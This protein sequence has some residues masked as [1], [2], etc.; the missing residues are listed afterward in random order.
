MDLFSNACPDCGSDAVKVHSRYQTAMNG[1]RRIHHCQNCDAYFSDTVATPI[2][3]LQTALSRVILILTARSEG[4]GMNAAARTFHV[5]KKSIIDWEWRLSDVKPTLL[6]Y[7]LVH[8][9]LDQIIEGDELYTKV[10]KNTAACDSEGWTI[11]LMERGSRFLWELDCGPKDQKLFESALQILAE[12]IEQTQDVTLLSDGERRYGNILF[13]IC[14][15]LVHTG[16]PGRPRKS[17]PKGVRVRLKNKGSKKRR[18]RPRAKYQAPV[19]EHPDTQGEIDTS[20]IHAN[21]V[22][23]FNAALRRRNSA[24]RRKT[25]TYAK[26]RLDLQRTLNRDWLIHNFVRIHFTTKQVP[27]VALGILETGLSWEQLFNIRYAC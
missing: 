26:T 20:T 9:F 19:T 8:Q 10:G 24:F 15:Q 12:V 22:E 1:E 23:A 4:M 27:S 14:H 25:N 2:A 18:G 17:L 7:S 6:L 21:H 5:S 3:G 13:S 16:G 11:V